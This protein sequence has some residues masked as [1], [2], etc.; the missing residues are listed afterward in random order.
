[1]GRVQV[2]GQAGDRE[3]GEAT[4]FQVS[5]EQLVGRGNFFPPKDGIT[6]SS[7]HSMGKTCKLNDGCGGYTSKARI[8]LSA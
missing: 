6:A 5:V 8:I 3:I 2:I 1:M 7:S 4:K